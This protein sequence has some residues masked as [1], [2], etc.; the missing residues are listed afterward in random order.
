MHPPD[1]QPWRRCPRCATWVFLPRGKPEAYPG[2]YYGS[3]VAKFS[4]WAQTLRARF[5]R[6]RARLVRQRLNRRIGKVYDVGCGDGLFLEEASGLGLQVTGFEPEPI[7]RGQAERRLGKAIDRKLFSSLRKEKASAITCWQVLEHLDDPLSFLR[8]C[9]QHLAD[10]GLLALSTV[11]LDSLQAK[12]F[13]SQW[14]HLDPPRHLWIGT[15]RGVVQLLRDCG[16]RV[17]KVRYNSLEFG[18]V[19]WVDS[20]FNLVDTERDRLLACLKQGCREPRDWLVYILSAALTPVA[21][22]LSLVEAGLHHPATFEIYAR[23][24]KDRA[25]RQGG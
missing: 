10:D 25:R 20:L 5:H 24:E 4:G 11:N 18:P 12:C 19:G 7:P 22:L 14:L 13:G 1:R 21:S 6:G 8:A 23:R 9:R 17:E 15:L 3:A 2:E 16:F